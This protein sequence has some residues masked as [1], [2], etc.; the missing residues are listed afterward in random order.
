MTPTLI[1][2]FGLLA[3]MGA[4]QAI[5]DEDGPTAW[6]HALVTGLLLSGLAA[7]LLGALGLLNGT[8]F[9]T[10][11]IIGL[12]G[13]IR[14]RCSPPPWIAV[15][16]AVALCLPGLLDALGPVSGIDEQY[17]HV[18]VSQQLLFSETLIGGPLHP[19]ASRP[20]TLQLIYA[21][22][23]SSGSPS[24]LACFHWFLS[25]AVLTLVVQIG[26]QY[27]GRW[28]T[29]VLAAGMLGLS[30]TIQESVGQAASDIP[31]ALAVLAAMD[32]AVRKRIRTG[33]IAAATAFSIKYTAAAPLLGVLVAS[34]L[35]LR[36]TIAVSSLMMLLVSPWWVR[37][38]LEG[39]H[40]LFP[41]TGWDEPN[42]AFQAAE[43]WGSGRGWTDF[44][45]LPYRAVFDANP[46]THTFHGRLHPFFLLGC[47]PIPIAWRSKRL[48]PWVIASL[49]GC[50]GWAIGPHWLRY[51]IPTLPLLALAAAAATAP[52]AHG[53]MRFALVWGGL[54]FL[55]P[56]GLKGT[57]QRIA[58]HVQ[59]LSS[60]TVSDNDAI[61][62]CNRHLPNDATVALLFSWNSAAI[63]RNQILGSVEDHIPTR[64]FLMRHADDPIKAL[65]TKGASHVLMRNVQFR[66]QVYDHVSDDRYITEFV[67]P[68]GRINSELLMNAELL[69]S[70]PTHRVYRLPT[71]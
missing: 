19:N 55:A 61:A 46:E 22:L 35:P 15:T 17:L 62:F 3:V 48:R 49:A 21:G 13:W 58:H 42:M 69:F 9:F 63:Q 43:K 29:G 33:T 39:L 64:H 50:V 68:V 2:A 59:N 5:T 31:T 20:L 30:T 23:L 70:D 37:N 32:A 36:Q 8:A 6:A 12:A 4:G 57:P 34:R 40:P 71:H 11:A 41:F 52:L 18:G 27:F 67:D 65:R 25:L 45:A 66:R 16:V 54:I 10:L 38:A 56:L 47:L 7:L 24:S 44:A 26:H 1:A 53:R 14:R 28:T 60:S 51:L